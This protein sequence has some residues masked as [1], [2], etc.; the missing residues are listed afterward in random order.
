MFEYREILFG[1]IVAGLCLI[2]AC[3]ALGMVLRFL[4]VRCEMFHAERMKALESGLPAPSPGTS[5]HSPKCTSS[6]VGVAF[7]MG[8]VFPLGAIWAAAWA[9][10]AEEF[11]LGHVLTV[12][13]A[14]S[15]ACVAAVICAAVIMIKSRP[16][17]NE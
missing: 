14:A 15:L 12:W 17:S 13:I 6:A 4:R 3:V 5:D 1:A 16:R 11:G 7:W 8:G 2:A 10:S 9:T